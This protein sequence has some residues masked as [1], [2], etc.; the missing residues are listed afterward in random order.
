MIEEFSSFHE[1]LKRLVGEEGNISKIM[2]VGAPDSGKTFAVEMLAKIFSPQRKIAI[3][4]LD[5]GQ[6]HIGPP[7]TVAWA[8]VNEKFE[9]WDLLR[10]RDFYFVGDTSPRGNLLPLVVGSKIIVEKAEK[11]CDLL[12]VDTT[13]LVRGGIGK[14]LKLSLIDTLRPDVVLAFSLENELN[15]IL[16]PLRKLDSPRIYKLPVSSEVKVKDVSA[17]FSYRQLKFKEYFKKARE[18]EFSLD[19]VEFDVNFNSNEVDFSLV[20][21]RDRHNRDTALG[22]IKSFDDR[23]GRIVVF[24]PVSTPE[25]VRRIVVGRLKITP[26]GHQL[27]WRKVW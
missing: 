1:A 25:N 6:S 12:I 17:R 10:M 21:L 20:S 19:E 27:P 22:I 16:F 18:V 2:M 8:K 3:I 13:G 23:E 14:V 7:T 11:E 9:S 26:E 5:P 24:S 4:D 15:H